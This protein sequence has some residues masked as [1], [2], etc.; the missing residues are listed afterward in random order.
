MKKFYSIPNRSKNVLAK[1]KARLVLEFNA[2]IRTRDRNLGCISCGTGPVDHAGHFYST[3]QCPQPSMRFN[4]KNVNGQC[5]NCN[6]F[7]EGNRQGYIKGLIKKYGPG[8]LEELE[9]I[10]SFKQNPWTEF[11]YK[12]LIRHYQEKQKE[13]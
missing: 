5:V 12:T 10:K 1:L 7:R 6:S 11:E 2:Y 13:F 9:I 4:E 3:S 8:I